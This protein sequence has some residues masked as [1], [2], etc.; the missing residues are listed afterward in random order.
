MKFSRRTAM[1]IVGAGALAPVAAVPVEAAQVP[2]A[3]KEGPTTPKIAVGMGDSGFPIG[4][5][6]ANAPADPSV[7]PR[8]IK[9]LGVNHVLSG[10]PRTLPW[11]EE[12]LNHQMEPWKAQGIS[13]SNLMINLS[14]DI[15]YGRKGD[16]RSEEHTSELQSHSF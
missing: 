9:Q 13:V 4:V 14:N 5:Q 3:P 10:G 6:G 2:P 1:Q 16:K 15:L 12:S 8:R 7:G 11:T